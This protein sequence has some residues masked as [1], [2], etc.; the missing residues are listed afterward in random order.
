MNKSKIHFLNVSLIS[1]QKDMLK[2]KG[3]KRRNADSDDKVL[4]KQKQREH[5]KQK[6]PNDGPQPPKKMNRR[7]RGHNRLYHHLT[8]VKSV[9]ELDDIVSKVL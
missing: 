2:Q 5:P 4:P 8:T 6:E 1:R 7:I 9:E 3:K